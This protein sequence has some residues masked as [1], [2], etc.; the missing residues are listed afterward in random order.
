MAGKKCN[1]H[2]VKNSAASGCAFLSPFFSALKDNHN[3]ASLTD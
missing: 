2:Y 1:P 3:F